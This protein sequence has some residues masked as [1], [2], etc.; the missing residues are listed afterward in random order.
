MINNTITRHDVLCA[1]SM[2]PG[3]FFNHKGYINV[4]RMTRLSVWLGQ[5]SPP[6]CPDPTLALNATRHLS[7]LERSKLFS[8]DLEKMRTAEGRWF[9]AI[10]YETFVEISAKTEAIRFLALKGADAPHGGRRAKL[11]QNGIF[12]SRAGDITIRGNGQDLAEFDLLMVDSEN[13]I[14]FTEVITSPSDLKEFEVE[15]EYKRRLLGYLFDQH[16]VPF[17]VVASFNVSNYTAGKRILKTPHTL[18]FQPASCEEIKSHLNGKQKPP[19]GWKPRPPH[20]K[21]VRASGFTFRRPFDYQKFHNQERDWVFSNVS[22]E[23]DVKSMASPHETSVL[24]KKILYG[25]LYPSAVRKVCQEYEFSIKGKKIGFDDIRRQFSKVILAT[26]LPGY[27]PIIYLRSKQKKEY[28][29]MVQDKEGNFK[30]E[31]FTPSKV[32][33]FLWLESLNPSLGSRITSNI[34]DAFSPQ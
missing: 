14:I 18:Y 33:F 31:R 12:Y 32:G 30:F 29:K 15:I 24:V 2:Y 20:Q 11:G 27:E 13:H 16:Y 22:N 6:S 17:I 5:Q 7:R 26:D 19:Y 10:I 3:Y 8:K 21:M 25:C 4:D 1:K 28:L 23:F 9:E 34:L